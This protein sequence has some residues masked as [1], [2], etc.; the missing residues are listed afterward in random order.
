MSRPSSPEAHWDQLETWLNAMTGILLPETA[1]DLQHL[2]REQLDDNLSAVMSHNPTQDYSYKE[3]AKI[4]GLLTYNLIAQAKMEEAKVSCLQ[5]E[6][7]AFRIQAEEA[8]RNLAQAH[9]QL[10]QIMAETQ[11]Q[12]E[13][14]DGKDVELQAEVKGLQQISA[15]HLK[16]KLDTAHRELKHAY[17]L[18]SDSEKE[19][20]NMEFSLTSGLISPKQELH[21]K[22]GARDPDSRP[23][24][25]VAPKELDK[26][27]RNIPTFT[28][29]PAGGYNIHAYLQNIDFHL[30]TVANVTTRDQ[31]YLLRVT[32]SRE[33]RSFLDRQGDKIKADYQQLQKALIKEFS[34]PE[35]EQGLF[36]ALD[37]KQSRHE[38]TQAYYNRLRQAYFGAR[39]EPGMEEDF[40]FK[41]LFLRNLHPAVSHHLGVPVCPR[42]MSIQ[43]LRDLARKAYTKQRTVPEKTVKGAAI[44]SVSEQCLE[45]ALEGTQQRYRDK[46]VQQVL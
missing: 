3:L 28:P 43:Q 9:D 46:P 4:L 45:L 36:T 30:Q 24:P 18:Q 11:S 21:F 35:S 5:Q 15:T 25:G 42:E 20:P 40:N 32:S 31:L 37:L 29:D 34:D 13:M 22:R 2:S 12:R 8:Q 33:V 38:T 10:D 26:L 39:N 7:L 1:V 27:S 17:R 6:S 16:D 19:L 23:P 14:A 41:T 44:Y